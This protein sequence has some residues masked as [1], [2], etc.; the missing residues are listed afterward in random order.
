MAHL[1]R[2]STDNKN[3]NNSYPGRQS[4]LSSELGS[5]SNSSWNWVEIKQS[6]GKQRKNAGEFGAANFSLYFFSEVLFFLEHK[7]IWSI[8]VFVIQATQQLPVLGTFS[9]KNPWQNSR[10]LRAWDSA[11]GFQ[12]RNVHMAPEYFSFS[13]FFKFKYRQYITLYYF[14]VYNIMI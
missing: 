14:Q 13:F 5:K 10:L 11:D 3:S 1:V 2:E 4:C 9:S 7:V 6:A 8:S 12:A